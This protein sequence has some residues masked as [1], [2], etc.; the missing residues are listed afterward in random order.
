MS[1]ADMKKIRAA[2]AEALDIRKK[3]ED[4]M[5]QIIAS[6]RKEARD[7]VESTRKASED[8]YK[9]SIAEAEKKASEIFEQ[10]LAG[11]KAACEKI[12]ADGRSRMDDVIDVIIGKVVGINGNS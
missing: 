2:E 5:A 8:A 6:G 12:K 1:I 11:E 4:D 9:A 10:T 3:A 7:L